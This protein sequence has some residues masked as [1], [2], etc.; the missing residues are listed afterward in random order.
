MYVQ[1]QDPFCPVYLP[2][3]KWV[4][5]FHTTWVKCPVT[6][7]E[8]W[9]PKLKSHTSSY[10]QNNRLSL[11]LKNCTVEPSL[12]PTCYKCGDLATTATIFWPQ[13]QKSSKSFSFFLF[14]RTLF[15]KNRYWVDTARF[16]FLVG[17][18]IHGVP[19]YVVIMSTP[20]QSPLFQNFIAEG[21]EGYS[22]NGLFWEARSKGYLFR[23]QA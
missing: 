8:E 16:L 20:W 2:M 11:I 14:W 1:F 21:E 7:R 22:Y 3:P 19:L 18:G 15:S 9:S 6:P 12:R 13:R 17:N 10:L 5:A 4:E 23:F